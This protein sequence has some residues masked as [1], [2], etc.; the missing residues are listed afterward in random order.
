MT[1]RKPFNR[2]HFTEE[3]VHK[4][5][6]KKKQYLIWDQGTGA[7]RGLAILVSPTGT[8]SFRVVFYWPGSVKP[9]YKNLG[10]VGEVNLADAR[11]LA[12]EA[13]AM[14]RKGDD[15][16]AG[17]VTKSDNFKLAIE[18]YIQHE[19][20]GRHKNTSALQTQKLMLACCQ[21]WE[22]RP[23]AT[24]RFA[25]IDALL[26]LMRD[27][28]SELKP[29]P[30]QANRLYSHLKDFFGWAVRKKKISMSPMAD[31]RKPFAKP[32]GRK[33][34]WFRGKPA[35]QAITSLWAA[36]DKIGG[37]EGKYI[38]LLLLTGKRKTALAG[39]RWEEIDDSWFW[40]APASQSKNKRLHAIPLPK[41]AQEV[42]HP[43]GKKGLVFGELNFQ[44]LQPQIRKASGLADFFYHGIRHLCE[45]KLAELK[46]PPHI[47]D[48]LFDHVPN[49]GTGSVY[50]HHEY[51]AEM[52]DTLN[53]WAAYIDKLRAPAKGI[54]VLR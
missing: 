45:S 17:A 9:N 48:Q 27:G 40:D 11:K 4:I 51:R 37:N 36:A 8:K 26:E 50:D 31:M 7:A 54:S 14:A 41:K 18:D 44:K 16:R 47:R 21:E 15:P 22:Q 32:E 34:V 12:W 13:R 5:P 19:Q 33:R 46:I 38:K 24:I 30:Y 53:T 35:D 6:A 20:V 39:M 25:E 1:K 42:L 3:N 23:I 43:R 10:R 29:R 28:N 2:K 49:R 52:L